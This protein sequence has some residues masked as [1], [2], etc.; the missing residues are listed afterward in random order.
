MKSPNTDL[1]GNETQVTDDELAVLHLALIPGIG[2][3]MQ[4]V[5]IETLGSADAVLRAAP[6]TL[7]QVPG[8]GPQLL[9]DIEKGRREI[10]PRQQWDFCIR[11]RV[12]ILHNE[13]ESYPR[14]LK[15]IFD[16]PGVLFVRGKLKSQDDGLGF[17]EVR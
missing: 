15:E 5:L 10:D 14:N 2:P 17:R 16:P 13:S 9:R 11:N 8:I 4:Q 1:P 6:S 7:R 12:E 3:R